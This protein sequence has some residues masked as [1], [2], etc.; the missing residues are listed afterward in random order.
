M[1][2]SLYQ[3]FIDAL[4]DTVGHCD[5]GFTPA[6]GDAWRKMVQKGVAYLQA[7]Y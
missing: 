5:P 6:V 2:P 7:K 1:D 4:I 3:P